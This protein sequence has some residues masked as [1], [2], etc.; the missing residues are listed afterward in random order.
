[1]VAEIACGQTAIIFDNSL[2]SNKTLE[3]KDLK[4]CLNIMMVA[5][6]FT[7]ADGWRMT[8]SALARYEL[9]GTFHVSAGRAKAS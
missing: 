3:I 5:E 2:L 1:M 6:I 7:R 9:R 4:A 8:G